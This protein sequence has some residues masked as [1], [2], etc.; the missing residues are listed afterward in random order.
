MLVEVEGVEHKGRE[1]QQIYIEDFGC[2]KVDV[3]Q[4]VVH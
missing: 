1:Q 2:M 3:L 4:V